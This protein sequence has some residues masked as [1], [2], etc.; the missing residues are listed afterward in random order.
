MSIKLP[1]LTAATVVLGVLLSSSLYGGEGGGGGGGFLCGMN[2]VDL[3]HLKAELRNKGFGSLKSKNTFFGGSGYGLI[4][5]KIII[6]GE[7]G[8]FTQ[9]V[10]GDTA[11]ARLS[12]GY[13]FFDVG[14]VIFSKGGWRLFPFIG[15]G[16]G[17]FNLRIVE[18]GPIPKFDELLQNPGREVNLT[19]ASF[20]F[21]FGIGLDYWLVIGEDEGGEG[22]LLFGMRAG[23]IISPSNADWKMADTDVLGGPDIRLSGPYIHLIFG[24]AGRER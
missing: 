13:G 23:Y 20:L 18:R 4:K 14:R 3:T 11:K 2:R 1:K 21:N 12:G 16:G 15:I 19:A 7:G 10:V 22:G 9:E 17:G 8:G 5:G 24:G 6:A